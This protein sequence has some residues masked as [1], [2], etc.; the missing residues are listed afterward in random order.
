MIAQGL[1]DQIREGK[2]CRVCTESREGTRKEDPQ[3]EFQIA[4]PETCATDII[5]TWCTDSKFYRG[6]LDDLNVGQVR[7]EK[8]LT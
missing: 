8:N 1:R 6:F 2:Q 5:V 3:L 4:T 7:H